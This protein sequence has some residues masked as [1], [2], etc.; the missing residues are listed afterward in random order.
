MPAPNLIADGAKILEV[1]AEII[2]PCLE[3]LVAAEGVVRE[4][5]PSSDADSPGVP[6]IYLPPFYQAERA[7]ASSLLR[8]LTARDDRLA[9]F[10]AVDWKAALRWLRRADRGV[11]GARAGERRAPWPD[12]EGRRT[13]R[14][15]RLR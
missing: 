2:G 12:L 1:S 10:S 6:A 3:E 4:E 11:T 15:P 14:W 7:L 9:A 8:L 13:Y 5:L